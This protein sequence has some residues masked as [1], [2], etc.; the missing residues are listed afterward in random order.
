[1]SFTPKKLSQQ[2]KEL[3]WKA[4]DKELEQYCR[5][6]DEEPGP[7][8]SRPVVVDVP[9]IWD[10]AL[11]YVD[12]GER[13]KSRQRQARPERKRTPRLTTEFPSRLSPED[14][15]AISFYFNDFDGLCGLKSNFQA[16][17]EAL[18]E[19]SVCGHRFV[20]NKAKL[21]CPH[22]KMPRGTYHSDSLMRV[23]TTGHSS[24]HPAQELDMIGTILSKDM[25]RCNLVREILTEM[26][27]K[28]HS[29]YVTVLFKMYGPKSPF[30]PY[31]TFGDLAP[32]AELTNAA[33]RAAKGSGKTVREFLDGN[34]HKNEV[35]RVGV[36]VAA[37][38]LLSMASKCYVECK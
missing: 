17:T 31:A 22:C 4:Q 24:W 5:F 3:L 36:R 30:L 6:P 7:K 16:C 32:L 29:K 12:E 28:G 15:S 11:S 19:C 35:L 34:L 8:F 20:N 27:D 2:E 33:E 13:K 14:V 21:N 23:K 38:K 37:E 1:M 26:V 10:C 25:E 18:D 9:D